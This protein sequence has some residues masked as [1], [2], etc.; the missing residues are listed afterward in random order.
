[1]NAFKN[2]KIGTR[3]G[4]MLAC[5]LAIMCGVAGAGVWGLDT[6]FGISTRVGRPDLAVR[7]QHARRDRAAAGRLEAHE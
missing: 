1:M 7:G 4:L 5:V 2:L 6:L 3:L